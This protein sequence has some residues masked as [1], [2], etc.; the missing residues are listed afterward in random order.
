[1]NQKSLIAIL[2]VIIV[3]T[4]A[5]I[6]FMAIN[7]SGQSVMPAPKITRQ[8]TQPALDK[9]VLEGVVFSAVDNALKI[10]Y[11]ST[12]NSGYVAWDRK[13]D[14]A[15]VDASQKAAKGKWWAKDAWDWIAWQQDD[16]GW[17]VFLSFDGFNCKDLDSIPSQYIAFF[18]DV[19]YPAGKKYCY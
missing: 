10:K 14:I 9:K 12:K 13:V 19:I 18:K 7:R 2:G 4:G 11:Q 6:Y 3:L 8:S 15:S 5:T 1:M 16:G 17:K